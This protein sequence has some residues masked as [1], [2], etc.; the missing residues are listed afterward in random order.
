MTIARALPKVVSFGKDD[1]RLLRLKA[2]RYGDEEQLSAVIKDYLNGDLE[3][4]AEEI[5]QNYVPIYE[6]LNDESPDETD[7]DDDDYEDD[8][9]RWDAWA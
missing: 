2:L 4:Y 7:E 9:G 6:S 8:D 5:V 3:E 1:A